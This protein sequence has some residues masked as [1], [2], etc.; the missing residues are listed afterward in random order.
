V[1]K[2]TL[3]L[4]AELKCRDKILKYVLEAVNSGMQWLD[5]AV[6]VWKYL[7]S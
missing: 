4:V 2:Q 7:P 6:A 5:W 3:Q 1:F